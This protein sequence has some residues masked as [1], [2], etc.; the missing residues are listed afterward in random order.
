MGRD[1]LSSLRSSPRS[2]DVIFNR[3]QIP[4][5]NPRE[6]PIIM[7]M[8]SVFSHRSNQYPPTPG[9]TISNETVVIRDTQA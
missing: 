1:L 5:G 7:Q 9:K 2:E 8:G 4:R 3:C 6:K